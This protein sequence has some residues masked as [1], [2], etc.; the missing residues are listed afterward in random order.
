VSRLAVHPGQGV[1]PGATV[2]VIVPDETYVIANLK[3]TQI[4]GVRPGERVD[5]EVDAFPDRTFHGKV[6]SIAAA[7]GARFSLLPPDNATGNFVKVVQHI[8][9]K[10]VWD[11]APDAALRAGLS[12]EVTIHV[13]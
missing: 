2:V 8:P 10:I 4:G 5:I 13:D 12:A 9:V 1:Q 11:P 7:T 3:E 6:A